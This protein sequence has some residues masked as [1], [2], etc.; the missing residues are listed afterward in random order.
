[1]VV[2]EWA[3]T[4]D[5][6]LLTHD[7]D[8]GAILAST[9]TTGPSVLQIRTQDLLPSAMEALLVESLRRFENELAI[10]SL[11][12]IDELRSRARILPL[13]R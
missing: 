10:G 13:S 3:L 5:H 9:Q 12:I 4:N 11:V 2:L 1:T 7:L 6:V 8:F